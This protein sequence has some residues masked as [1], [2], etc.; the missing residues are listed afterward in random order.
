[1]KTIKRFTFG[2]VVLFLIQACANKTE[3]MNIKKDTNTIDT[4]TIGCLGSYDINPL[5]NKERIN[6][7]YGKDHIKDGHWITFGFA[8]KKMLRTRQIELK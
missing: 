1:M 7:V 6:Q 4:L 8:I 5:D 3:A 2:T